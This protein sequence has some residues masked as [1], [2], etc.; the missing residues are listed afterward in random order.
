MK[1]AGLVL[2]LLL[3]GC[4]AKKQTVAPT[5][6]PIRSQLPPPTAELIEHCVITAQENANTVT[7]SCVPAKTVIDSKT[8][9]TTL[10]CKPMKEEK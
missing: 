2:C 7:C 6:A 3:V 5:P 8:G 9:H 4:A 1:K 10:V